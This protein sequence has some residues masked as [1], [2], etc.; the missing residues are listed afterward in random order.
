ML[1]DFYS[2]GWVS[3]QEVSLYPISFQTYNL[4]NDLPDLVYLVETILNGY[5]YF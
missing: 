1:S 2:F 4:E 5:V 3:T